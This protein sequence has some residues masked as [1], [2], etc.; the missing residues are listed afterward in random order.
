MARYDDKRGLRTAK[1][2]ALLERIAEI[3]FLVGLSLLGIISVVVALEI[4]VKLARP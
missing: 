1:D 2:G 3:L 4:V